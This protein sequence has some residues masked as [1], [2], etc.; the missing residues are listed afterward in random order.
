MAIRRGSDDR[1]NLSATGVVSLELCPPSLWQCQP[2]ALAVPF[3]TADIPMAL[4]QLWLLQNLPHCLLRAPPTS[5]KNPGIVSKVSC[6]ISNAINKGG[7]GLGKELFLKNSRGRTSL[8][9]LTLT[10]RSTQTIPFHLDIL[11][12]NRKKDQT[13]SSLSSFIKVF[14]LLRYCYSY[15]SIWNYNARKY[16]QWISVQY[17]TIQCCWSQFLHEFTRAHIHKQWFLEKIKRHYKKG[18]W[19]YQYN[20]VEITN[21]VQHVIKLKKKTKPPKHFFISE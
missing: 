9:S 14:D 12:H 11:P 5:T 15:L 13:T 1:R 19:R 17:F 10:P 4:L 8:G 21:P 20:R 18:G 7:W 2:S 3:L 16:W 6:S